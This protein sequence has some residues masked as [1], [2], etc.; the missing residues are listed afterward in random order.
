MTPI[1]GWWWMGFSRPG[2]LRLKSWVA[3]SLKSTAGNSARSPHPSSDCCRSASRKLPA[4]RRSPRPI[5][6]PL[7]LFFGIVQE[8]D[9]D[10]LADSLV[11]GGF[12]FTR[13]PTAGGFLR[14]GNTTFIIGAD[15]D[16]IGDLLG[17][18]RRNATT[19]MQIVSP[20][21]TVQDPVEAPLPFPVEVQVGG[22]TMFMFDLERVEQI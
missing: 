10:L 17:I 6:P 21:Q 2:T 9:A 22:A 3:C 12:R 8:A 1:G 18:V 14:E 15:E 19:R 20:E 16:R 11:S 5:G 4:S 7:K 13:V